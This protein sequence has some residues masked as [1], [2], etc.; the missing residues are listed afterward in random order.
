MLRGPEEEEE[1]SRR[2]RWGHLATDVGVNRMNLA[3]K[4]AAHTHPLDLPPPPENSVSAQ[5]PS[6]TKPRA[7]APP[8][9]TANPPP[10]SPHRPTHSR[11]LQ[12]PPRA[13]STGPSSGPS[14]SPQPRLLHVGTTSS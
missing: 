5:E 7:A 11:P 10:W 1:G 4:G 2:Q 13:S 8:C 3:V 14:T 9:N 6:S 12:G